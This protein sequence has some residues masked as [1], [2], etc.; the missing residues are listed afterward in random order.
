MDF[1]LATFFLLLSFDTDVIIELII[2]Y[3][4]TSNSSAMLGMSWL[5]QS[6]DLL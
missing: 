2:D 1:I 3:R 4:L 5:M 6:H